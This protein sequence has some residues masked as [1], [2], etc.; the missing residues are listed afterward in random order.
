M[1]LG[2]YKKELGGWRYLF[3]ERKQTKRMLY[4]FPTLFHIVLLYVFAFLPS[5][6]SFLIRVTPPEWS[7]AH[8]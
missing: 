8:V 5:S 6:K 2:G 4:Y 1:C 3:E 7:T